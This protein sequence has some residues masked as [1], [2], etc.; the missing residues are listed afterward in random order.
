M[1]WLAAILFPVYLPARFWPGFQAVFDGAL[2]PDWVHISLHLALYAGL[3]LLIL[4]LSKPER[5]RPWLTLLGIVILVGG[6]Q[7][8]FQSLSQGAFYLSG[9]IF[10]LGV[11][12]L[13]AFIGYG[14]YRFYLGRIYR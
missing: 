8:I 13:G 7:E 4:C 14:L 9:T 1:F 3:A 11:D 10:D 2:K 12:V 6:F 5:K